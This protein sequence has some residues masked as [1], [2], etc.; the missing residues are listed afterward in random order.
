MITKQLHYHK[1]WLVLAWCWVVAVIYLSLTSSPPKVMEFS[2]AD[3]LGH[4][5][6]YCWLMFWFAQ[7]YPSLKSRLPYATGLILMGIV[8]EFL[9]SLTPARLFEVADMLANSTGVLI[10]LWVC[11][12]N[13]ANVFGWIERRWLPG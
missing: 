13:L 9:Q 2:G 5:L 4:L 1:F 3:K 10:G 7:L 12:G 8:L 11:R 6:T